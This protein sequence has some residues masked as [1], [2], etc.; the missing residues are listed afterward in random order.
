[1]PNEVGPIIKPLFESEGIVKLLHGCEADVKNLY[2]D[3]GI[4]CRNLF[5]TAQAEK[6][7]F[8]NPGTPGLRFL[9]DKIMGV[10]IDK[11]FQSSTWSMRPLPQNMYEYAVADAVLLFP[12]FKFYVDALRGD[13]SS[14]DGLDEVRIWGRSNRVEKWIK[15][16]DYSI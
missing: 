7:L 5:D 4:L 10:K 8:R 13:I 16:S 6:V 14:K 2:Q 15:K 3:F 9:V 12:I 1:M 11:S